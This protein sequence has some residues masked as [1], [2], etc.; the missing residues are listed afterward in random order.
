MTSSPHRSSLKSHLKQALSK[1]WVLPLVT[2]LSYALNIAIIPLAALIGSLLERPL[3]PIIGQIPALLSLLLTLLLPVWLVTVIIVR[4]RRADKRPLRYHWR[5]S[6]C[7][8]LAFIGSIFAY[9]VVSIVTNLTFVHDY[10]T[11]D[12]SIPPNRDFVIP[13][14][15]I[16]FSNAP[17]SPE[18]GRLQALRPQPPVT[19]QAKNSTPAT[20]ED[21]PHLHK[22]TQEAPELLQ[23]YILRAL[24]AE[25]TNPRFQSS[26]LAHKD[27]AFLLHPNDPQSQ[28][29][30]KN[31]M[32]LRSRTKLSDAILTLANGWSLAFYHSWRPKLIYPEDAAALEAEL[33]PLAANPTRRQLD[34]MLPPLP[35]HPFLCL[36]DAQF[37]G[38]SY[39]VLLVVPPDYPTGSFELNVREISQDKP[40]ELSS[41]Q[42]QQE[43]LPIGGLGRALHENITVYSGDWGE[44]YASEWEV[45]FTPAGGGEPRQVA[46]QEFL[47]MGWQR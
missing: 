18:V 12:T 36:W 30:C 37:D 3:P 4:K 25:A 45:W 43:L 32:D 6:F 10:F 17:L 20:V 29:L 46:A 27:H 34:S 33:A 42:L 39:N 21:V 41:A 15:Q 24:Y 1:S 40:V 5:W 28:I 26:V 47:I 8:F 14:E 16:F 9:F 22:L 11:H 7:T 2:V 44:Y 19:E 31:Q 23:E 13:R 35:K 38:G